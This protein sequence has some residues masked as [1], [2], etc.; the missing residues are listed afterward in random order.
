MEME[1]EIEVLSNSD[2]IVW[3]C[4]MLFIIIVIY[5]IVNKL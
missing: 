4:G 5:I 3:S 1:T 2:A